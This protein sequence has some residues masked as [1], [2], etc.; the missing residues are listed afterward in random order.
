M[1]ISYDIQGEGEPIIFVHG[2][3]SRKFSWNNV[4]EELK[5]KYQCITYS[6]RGHGDS[7]LPNKSNNFSLDDLV[8]DLESLRTYL[9][10][11]R[12]NLVGHSL[13]G[14]IVPA[15]AKKFPAHTKSLVMLST[16]AF[17]SDKEKEKVLSLVG[18]MKKT[19][20]DSVLPL[21]ISRW[22]TKDFASKNYDIVEK[23][24][25][26]IKK[27]SLETFC[28]VFTI[29]ANCK[30][31]EWLHEINIPTLVMTGSEDAGC[32]P[33]LNRMI[34]KSMPQAKLCVLEGLKH[35]I[36]TERPDLVSE[37]IKI[38]LNKI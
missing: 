8:E 16:A 21:L 24:I 26:M 38:F 22:Y 17:R 19:G 28:R 13:G 35:S 4:V 12:T 10:L 33:R 3:G 1:D 5:D 20:L 31:E 15:Y 7:V 30:M 11:E 25:D 14:Q 29:Y 36:N 23:R 2:V 9:K 18:K 32:S 6:L 27:M 37:Q 34:V